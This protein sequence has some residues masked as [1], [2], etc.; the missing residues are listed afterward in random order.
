MF[1]TRRNVEKRWPTL[2]R[3]LMKLLAFSLRKN[4]FLRFF[5]EK[6]IGE[7][8]MP[9]G[10]RH[11]LS[12]KHNNF[13]TNIHL[14]WT[15]KIFKGVRHDQDQFAGWKCHCFGIQGLLLN[16]FIG[17]LIYKPMYL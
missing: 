9:K 13:S 3:P 14:F 12:L 10:F 1:E 5:L 15:R 7:Q 8:S 16:P 4:S 6:I 17:Y 11:F 2:P